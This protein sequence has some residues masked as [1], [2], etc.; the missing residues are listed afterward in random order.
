[1][2]KKNPKNE[3]KQSI[4]KSIQVC[5]PKY[6]PILNI[7]R[8]K[9]FTLKAYKRGW[10][11]CRDGVLRIHSSRDAAAKGEPPSFSVELRGAEVNK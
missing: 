11:S 2:N 6:W 1:M 7:F 5:N 4:K 8:P 9:R 10:M 3:K